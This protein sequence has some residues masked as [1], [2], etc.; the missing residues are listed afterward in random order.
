MTGTIA[1]NLLDAP[2]PAD[3]EA[4]KMVLGS[5]LTSDNPEETFTTVSDRLRPEDF[6]DDA[7]RII[8]EAMNRLRQNNMPIDLKLLCDSLKSTTANDVRAFDEVG[9]AAYIHS[10]AKSVPKATHARY[11]A[12][13]VREKADKRQLFDFAIQAAQAAHNGKPAAD[14]IASLRESLDGIDHRNIGGMASPMTIGALV[15]GNASLAPMIIDRLLRGG[16]TANIIAAPKMGK[17]WL[18]YDLALSVATGGEWLGRY[19]CERGRVLLIDNELHAGT[20]AHRIPTVATA[21]G[22]AESEY[23]PQIDVLSLRGRLI[24]LHGIA[25]LLMPVEPGT[26]SL[27]ILD[28]WYRAL[29]SGANENDNGGIAM[30]YNLIDQM[31][32]NLGCA[33]VNI[34]HAS[35]GAQADKS[36][37]DVG[38]G[39]GS[40]S[41]AADTHI[42]LRPHEDE[43]CIVLDAVVRSSA[44]VEPLALRWQYPCW[45]PADELDAS[46]L[47]RPESARD[48]KQKADD[49]D[50]IAKIV[51]ALTGQKQMTPR[52]LRDTGLSRDR[53]KRLLDRLYADKRV[54]REP[55]KIRGNDTFNYR[56]S[57]PHM[58]VGDE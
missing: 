49:A 30:L 13:N 48:R 53:L 18:A 2:P 23:R 21:L 39:A 55:T 57:E 10:L 3:T 43:G 35:K 44:P 5:V 47:R 54:S 38:A 9:G 26:Y 17:S 56:L 37:T 51:S 7:N 34:H 15:A 1:R 45:H 16:E 25:R 52:E 46:R 42:I 4:E 50:G 32:A 11:Y 31:A 58:D 12:L 8:F 6:H 14:V 33:W 36:V 40:Q 22:I 19:R 28:A 24:D 20:L 29:P 41:R 27:I